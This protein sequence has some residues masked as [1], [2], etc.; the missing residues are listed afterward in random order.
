MAVWR[1]LL[2]V[3]LTDSPVNGITGI[4]AFGFE[5]FHTSAHYTKQTNLTIDS[6]RL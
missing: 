4:D 1:V 2:N 6:E 3:S 5:R